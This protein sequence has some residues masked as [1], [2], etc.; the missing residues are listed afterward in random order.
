MRP[1]N[2]GQEGMNKAAK[3]KKPCVD[4]REFYQTGV[5]LFGM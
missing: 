1:E 4:A 2:L 5:G 3:D